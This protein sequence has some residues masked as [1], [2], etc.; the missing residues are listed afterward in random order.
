MFNGWIY[1]MII[2]LVC[3]QNALLQNFVKI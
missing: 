2:K 1:Y 3:S